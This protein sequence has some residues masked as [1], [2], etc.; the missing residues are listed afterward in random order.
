MIKWAI[1]NNEDSFVVTL[2]DNLDL[3]PEQYQVFGY[4]VLIGVSLV[5]ISLIG[6]LNWVKNPLWRYK[7]RRLAGH[8]EFVQT[9]TFN[10][11]VC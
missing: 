8:R 3:I 5:L 2:H 10:S 11:K 1:T 4:F 7:N 6:W 9:N